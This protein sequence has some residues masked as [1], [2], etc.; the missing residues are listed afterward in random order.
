MD[1]RAAGWNSGWDDC[2]QVPY[3]Q[4]PGQS[5]LL[6]YD[7]EKSVALKCRFI[8]EKQAA[9]VIIWEISQDYYGGDSVL[10]GTVGKEFAKPEKQR[11]YSNNRAKGD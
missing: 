10:L 5:V 6:S 7:D 8:K 2:A 11:S 9:G 3:L 1:L 4:N